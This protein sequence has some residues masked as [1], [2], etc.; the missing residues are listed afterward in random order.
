MAIVFVKLG[1]IFK[2]F[3]MFQKFAMLFEVL[4]NFV[5]ILNENTAPH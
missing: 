2:D 5:F 1:T 4:K 3:E